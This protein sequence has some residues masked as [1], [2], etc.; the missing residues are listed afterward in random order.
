MKGLTFN[1]RKKEYNLAV[2][3]SLPRLSDRER[4]KKG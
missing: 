1:V 2:K 3:V 4:V